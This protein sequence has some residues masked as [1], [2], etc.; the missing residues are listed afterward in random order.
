MPPRFKQVFL[1]DLGIPSVPDPSVKL[2]AGAFGAVYLLQVPHYGPDPVAVKQFHDTNGEKMAQHEIAILSILQGQ[3]CKTYYPCLL[4]YFRGSDYAFYIVTKYA[5][6]TDLENA[7][8]EHVFNHHNHSA[9]STAPAPMQVRRFAASFAQAIQVLHSNGISHNDVKPENVKVN[10]DVYPPQFVL[11]DFGVSCLFVRNAKSPTRKQRLEQYSASVFDAI[12]ESR[13]S[14]ATLASSPNSPVA[15]L[16]NIE[17]YQCSPRALGTP[18]YMSPSRRKMQQ[19]AQRVSYSDELVEQILLESDTWAMAVSI[20]EFIMRSKFWRSASDMNSSVQVREMIRYN[21]LGLMNRYGSVDP[22]L[23]QVLA[24]ILSK[25]YVD[26]PRAVIPLP[27]ALSPHA[28]SEIE[29]HFP[30]FYRVLFREP[31]HGTRETL[32]PTLS[33][34]AQKTAGKVPSVEPTVVVPGSSLVASSVAST[35]AA[36]AAATSVSIRRSSEPLFGSMTL[37]KSGKA[38]RKRSRG[39]SSATTKSPS[40]KKPKKRKIKLSQ[41]SQ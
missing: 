8:I 16:D 20:W 35:V 4:D 25:P 39:S 13:K 21:L 30:D 7:S 38:D 5:A 40:P 36:T 18:L 23:C 37:S 2:G 29:R 12:R 19:T 33:K 15:R 26:A 3:S 17:K 22:V 32:G 27:P 31:M 10:F 24:Y 6:G 11:L 41:S 1:R 34:N 14:C 9:T 28:L